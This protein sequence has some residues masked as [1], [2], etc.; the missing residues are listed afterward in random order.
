MLADTAVVIPALIPW[1]IAGLVPLTTI[2]APV[3][4]FLFACYLY[5]LPLCGIIRSYT[6]YSLDLSR[7]VGSDANT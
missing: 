1:T 4:S 2:N 5:L 3:T 7:N 6:K